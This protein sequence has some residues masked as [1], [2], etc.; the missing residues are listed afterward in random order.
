MNALLTSI[1]E[2]ILSTEASENANQYRGLKQINGTQTGQ[3]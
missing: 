2:I 3:K 1:A